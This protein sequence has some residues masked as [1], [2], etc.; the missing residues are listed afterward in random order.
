MSD[1]YVSRP[2]LSIWGI[3]EVEAN[4]CEDTFENRQ[5]LIANKVPYSV[6]EPGLIEVNFQDYGELNKHHASQFEA[7]KIILK[8]PK[9]PWSDFVPFDELP[10]D[11]LETAPAWI[12]RHLNKYNDAVEAGTSEHKLPLL[13]GRCR[14][15]RADGSRCWQ[16]GWPAARAEGFCRSHTSSAAFNATE[17]MNKLSDAAKMRL[18]QLTG[19]SLEALEDLVLNSTVPHVRLKAATEVLDRVGI[20]GGSELTVSGTVQHEAVDPATVVMEKLDLLRKRHLESEAAAAE[21]MAG[22]GAEIV[23]EGE[24]VE[25]APHD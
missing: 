3:E 19:P 25:D 13:P 17:Q 7:K 12:Q 8:N 21:L 5:K 4:V 6:L 11:Y 22:E 18:S 16:W 23:I 10:L 2:S 15:I 9:D 24:V 20:R 14:R 1:E